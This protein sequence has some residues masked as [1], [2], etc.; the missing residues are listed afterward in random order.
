MLIWNVDAHAGILKNKSVLNDAYFSAKLYLF[1]VFNSKLFVLANVKL[2]D[3]KKF[4]LCLPS[5]TAFTKI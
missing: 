3:G 5:G 4:G 1:A 2:K